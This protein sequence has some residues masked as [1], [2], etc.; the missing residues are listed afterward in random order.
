MSDG[1]G[2]LTPSDVLVAAAH[3]VAFGTPIAIAVLVPVNV[4]GALA[5]TTPFGAPRPWW[6]FPS[7]WARWGWVA[8]PIV[9]RAI[10]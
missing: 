1:R 7:A 2:V 5:P 4:V 6:C 9:V 3:A 10:D 8:I